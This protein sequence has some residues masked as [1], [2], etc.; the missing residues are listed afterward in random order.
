MFLFSCENMHLQKQKKQLKYLGEIYLADYLKSTK[1]DSKIT[2]NKNT[3]LIT[4]YDLGHSSFYASTGVL[5][6]FKNLQK[7]IQIEGK[8][9]DINSKFN[10]LKDSLKLKDIPL[11]SI[12]KNM[13]QEV[14]KGQSFYI[15]STNKKGTYLTIKEKLD[16]K[17]TKR[18]SDFVPN[19]NL[20]FKDLMG[21]KNPELLVLISDPGYWD[22]NSFICKIYDLN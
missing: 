7:T 18:I 2:V 4:N 14:K 16:T 15:V 12:I 21:D 8:T 20:C 1:Y 17:L 13:N 9:N 10:H 22:C 5:Q 11:E 6:I 3:L 19:V